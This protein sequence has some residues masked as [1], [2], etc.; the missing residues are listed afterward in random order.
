MF[1]R[2][3]CLHSSVT[4]TDPVSPAGER[5]GPTNSRRPRATE[6]AADSPTAGRPF[7]RRGDIAE[8]A[9]RSDEQEQ[10]LSST[11][12][13]RKT[14]AQRHAAQE[15]LREQV[16]ADSLQS[17]AKLIQLNEELT[18]RRSRYASLLEIQRS[19]EDFQ[20]GVRNVMRHKETDLAGI[21]GL[22]AD[23]VRSPPQYEQAVEAALGSSLQYIIVENHEAGVAAIDGGNRG[24]R[25]ELHGAFSDNRST[26]RAH[27]IH[28]NR[29]R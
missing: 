11:E 28:E 16:R 2:I 10:T 17:E 1:G 21:F 6:S 18:Q 19:Y 12:A 22:V 20:E 23:V 8:L 7:G 14:L 29:P 27:I 5:G 26:K 15:S 9:Q 13:E 25:G 24:E 3:T 4:G